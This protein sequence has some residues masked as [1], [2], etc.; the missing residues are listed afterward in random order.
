MTKLRVSL[1]G[2]PCK[3]DRILFLIEPHANKHK[4]I[5]ALIKDIVG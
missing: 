2:L 1:G 3:A 4:T 5:E